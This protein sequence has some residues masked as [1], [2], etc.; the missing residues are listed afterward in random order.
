M[1]KNENGEFELMVGNKQLLS[2]V[3]ILMV[4]FGVVFTMGYFVG[5]NSTPEMTAA[6]PPARPVPETTSSGRPEP[7][8]GVPPSPAPASAP[9]PSTQPEAAEPK[10]AETQP[11]GAASN[12]PVTQPVVQ[13]VADA[14]P[15]TPPVPKPAA[16][17]AAPAAAFSEPAPGQSFLQVA[18]VKRPEAELIVDVLKKKGFPAM[19]APVPNDTLFRVLVGPMR[20]SAALAKTKAD[21]ETAGFRSL[22][23]K[24]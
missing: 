20:D 12:P 2:I 17:P 23:R 8:E 19:V 7:A 24:Y 13:R 22:V 18:A 5:R 11:V 9:S 4:L 15:A 14:K 1:A 10:P 6:A 3:F 16:E 21:L